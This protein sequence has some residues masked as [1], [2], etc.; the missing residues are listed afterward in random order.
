MPLTSETHV[1]ADHR[2]VQDLFTQRGWG[3]GFPVVPPTPALVESFVVACGLA[4]DTV[5]GSIPEQGRDVTVEKL[6][7]NAVAAGCREEYMSVLV[8]TVRA[9]TRPEFNLHS[10]TVSGA[11]AP[12]LVIGGPVVDQLSV[13]SSYSVFGPGHH[14][15]ATI[16]RAVRLLLQNVCG[17]IPGVLDRATFGHPGKFSYCIGESTTADPWASPLHADRGADPDDSAVTVLAGEAPIN[18]RNDWAST[19]GPILATIA[20][21]MLPSHYTG[22]CFLV[23]LGPL[24]ARVLAGAGL[25][26]ADVRAE[27][28]ARARRSVA[29]LRRAGRVPDGDPR[30]DDEVV[31]AVRG[32]QDI[33]LTVAGGDLYGYSAVV[34]PWIGGHDS[35]PVTEALTPDE[36]G[37]CQVPQKET[38]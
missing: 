38:S 20:D 1:V 16:G 28:F 4:P 8:A 25:S 23:V 11:T 29:E 10:T 22:G 12:L 6:A 9:L 26:R 13:N 31:P 32:P 21:A 18:A 35:Q 33:L 27:L 37:R 2:A 3:D 7:V 14:A 15:N 5:L 19:P 36:A 34:P 17:G 30:G 24:H